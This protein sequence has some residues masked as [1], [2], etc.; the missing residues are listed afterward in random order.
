MVVLHSLLIFQ[1]QFLLQ[2][3]PVQPLCKGY[4]VYRDK[5]GLQGTPGLRWV[6][7]K[8]QGLQARREYMQLQQQIYFYQTGDL[9]LFSHMN[10]LGDG[11][12]NINTGSQSCPYSTYVEN[13]LTVEIFSVTWSVLIFPHVIFFFIIKEN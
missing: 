13:G 6:Y 10:N 7:G 3:F 4:W 12:D 8:R 11:K 5:A 1:Q 9:L 2:T